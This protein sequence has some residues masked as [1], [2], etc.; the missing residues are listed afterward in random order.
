MSVS[1]NE[2]AAHG[3]K[4]HGVCDVDAPLVVAHEPSPNA[5]AVCHSSTLGS[6]N[7]S[8]F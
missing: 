7:F 2:I 5:L 1:S 4:D 8:L 6:V 3:H